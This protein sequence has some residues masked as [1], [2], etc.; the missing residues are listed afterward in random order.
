MLTTSYL[1]DLAACSV[2]SSISAEKLCA[3]RGEIAE[4]TAAKI[5][6]FIQMYSPYFL[7]AHNIIGVLSQI[8]LDVGCDGK[9]L[10][11]KAGHARFGSWL[12]GNASPT[13]RGAF[14]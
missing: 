14:S 7:K 13:T 11:R 1:F 10:E 3:D 5:N 8:L 9:K 2:A 12:C 6:F 4:T